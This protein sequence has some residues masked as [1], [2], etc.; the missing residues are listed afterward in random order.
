MFIVRPLS[1]LHLLSRT[2]YVTSANMAVTVAQFLLFLQKD[3]KCLT[4]Q[5]LCDKL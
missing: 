1:E 2:I 5:Q 4:V 3:G